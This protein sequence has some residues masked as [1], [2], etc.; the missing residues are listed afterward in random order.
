MFV[1]ILE[2]L[3]TQVV[4]SSQ[5][6]NDFQIMKYAYIEENNALHKNLY[7]IPKISNMERSIKNT[8]NE[9]FLMYRSAQ[10]FYF[11]QWKYNIV[12]NPIPLQFFAVTS[13]DGIY[14]WEYEEVS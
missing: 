8:K 12:T 2:F 6:E 4:K 10:L 13:S 5:K 3:L 1:D 14:F 9:L 7:P 11:K